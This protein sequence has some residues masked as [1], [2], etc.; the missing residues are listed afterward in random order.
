VC[1][2]AAFEGEFKLDILLG[3][4]LVSSAVGKTVIAVGCGPGHETIELAKP[5]AIE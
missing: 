5:G 1:S 4:G 2:G 3:R